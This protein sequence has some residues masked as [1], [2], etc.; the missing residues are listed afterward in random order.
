MEQVCG[1]IGIAGM[2][3]AFCAGWVIAYLRGLDKQIKF[4][5]EILDKLDAQR[6]QFYQ[7]IEA[8]LNQQ[9]GA[10]SSVDSIDL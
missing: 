9:S 1:W 7:D 4:G 5:H 3:V 10:Q 2:A 6:Q 8:A